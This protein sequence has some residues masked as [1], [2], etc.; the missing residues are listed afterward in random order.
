VR[1]RHLRDAPVAFAAVPDCQH[2]DDGERTM[3]ILT[4]CPDGE[5][6]SAEYRERPIAVLYRHG[7]M[8]VYLDHVLQHDVVFESG[9][10]A[11]AWLVQRI[12]QGVPAR[13]NPAAAFRGMLTA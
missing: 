9:P 8:H 5:F 6:W 1:D 12:D 4:Q 2:D 13:V 10:D 7:R 11:L 3:Q